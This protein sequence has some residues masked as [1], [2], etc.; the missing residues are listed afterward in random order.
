MT[1]GSSTDI[2]PW[3]EKIRAKDPNKARMLETRIMKGSYSRLKR[4]RLIEKLCIENKMGAMEIHHE[5]RRMVEARLEG[6]E[7]CISDENTTNVWSPGTIQ[8]DIENMRRMWNGVVEKSVVNHRSALVQ[9]LESVKKRSWETNNMKGVVS[10]IDRQVEILGLK[11]P[12]RVEVK[13]G[14]LDEWSQKLEEAKR[15]SAE[16]DSKIVDAEVVQK[17]QPV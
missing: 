3:I 10:A 1:V 9:E 11:Q 15:R 12:E 4:H 13:H 7:N 17:E 6:W 5:M 8:R 14:L 16:K 2:K